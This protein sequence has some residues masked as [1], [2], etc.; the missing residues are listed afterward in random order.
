MENYHIITFPG[1]SLSK[2]LEEAMNLSRDRLILE[3][4]YLEKGKKIRQPGV[5]PPEDKE[6]ETRKHIKSFNILPSH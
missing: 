1:Q 2:T 6:E 3:L 4:D 5:K